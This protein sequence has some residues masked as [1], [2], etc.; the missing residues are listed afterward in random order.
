MHKYGG[1]GWY[2]DLSESTSQIWRQLGDDTS[3]EFVDGPHRQVLAKH[4]G[5]TI[6]LYAE[7]LVGASEWGSTKHSVT[8]VTVPY[9]SKDGFE[10][11]IEPVWFRR[12]GIETGY[13][14]FDREFT[15]KSNDEAKLRT[16]LANNKVRHLIQSRGGALSASCPGRK[17]IH[18]LYFKHENG[19]NNMT[20]VMRHGTDYATVPGGG[21][22]VVE[23]ITGYY[24][25]KALFEMFAET[26]DQLKLQGSAQGA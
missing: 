21:L 19:S 6:A 2:R 16:L 7:S 3:A 11:K 15:I 4:R 18:E 17:G 9:R 12:H 8:H 1:I 14:D 10:F 26:L 13:N 25:L 22:K 24:N 5:W 20:S 23:P